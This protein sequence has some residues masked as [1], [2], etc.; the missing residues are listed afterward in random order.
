MDNPY[1][2]PINIVDGKDPSLN[3]IDITASVG[4]TD[5]SQLASPATSAYWEGRLIPDNLWWPLYSPQDHTQELYDIIRYVGPEK[6][7]IKYK[8]EPSMPKKIIQ[9]VPSAKLITR[10]A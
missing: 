10:M 6:R 9:T 5:L 2:L 8:H 4:Y 7:Y 1:G 3:D